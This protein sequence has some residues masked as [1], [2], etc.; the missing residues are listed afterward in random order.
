MGSFTS[1]VIGFSTKAKQ[2]SSQAARVAARIGLKALIEYTPVRTGRL[3]GNWRVGLG[4]P[5][6]TFRE[7]LKDKVGNYTLARG[8]TIINRAKF[9]ERIYVTNTTPYGKWVND[10]TARISPRRFVE[11][12]MSAIRAQL[13]KE[14]STVAKE[15]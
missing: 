12:A 2:R 3:K 4:Q 14:L 1:S 6:L 5:D 11:R 13:P 9:D 15:R 10:G 7:N 8:L